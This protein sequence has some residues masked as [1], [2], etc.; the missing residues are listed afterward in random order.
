MPPKVVA[1]CLWGG[2]G[3]RQRSITRRDATQTSK[4][5]SDAYRN[6]N[7]VPKPLIPIATVPMS[8]IGVEKLNAAGIN[9]IYATT[10]V[11]HDA[12]QAYYL[13]GAG[14][15][16][17][18]KELWYENRPMG[19]APGLV[20]NL[21]LRASLREA[22]IVAPGGDIITDIN[23]N[24]FLN[25]HH[26]NQS[27]C[28]I[29]LNPVS[30]KVVHNFGTADF[31]PLEGQFGSI[32]AFKEK[33]PAKEAFGIQIEN[34]T[35]F[36]NN[37]SFYVFNPELFLKPMKGNKSILEMIFPNM[38][39]AL[40]SEIRSGKIDVRSDEEAKE[41]FNRFGLRDKKFSDFGGH[42]FPFLAQEGLMRGFVFE[43]YWN[44]VG[45]NETYWFANWH[46]LTKRFKMNL[47]YP[48]VEPGVWM[49][50]DAERIEGSVITPPVI[51]GKNVKIESGAKVGPYA[52]LDEG[53]TVERGAE[54][55]YSLTWPTFTTEGYQE[56]IPYQI[57]R[58]G[59]RIE[60]SIIAGRLPVGDH[61]FKNSIGDGSTVDQSRLIRTLVGLK[62]AMDSEID[63]AKQTKR[64]LVVDDEKPFRDIVV[65]NL[66]TAGWEFIETAGDL[67]EAQARL[68][69][70]RYDIIILDSV[71]SQEEKAESEGVTILK[72]QKINKEAL[73]CETPTLFWS[74]H[75]SMEALKGLSPKE[76]LTLAERNTILRVK[77]D[78]AQRDLS[79][80][81][82]KELLKI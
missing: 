57:I 1:I 46:A 7:A 26:E 71:L 48:E 53:W 16:L 24:D 39:A 80:F 27:L 4:I 45:D 42:I 20:I 30:D 51:I 33:A 28:T 64:V 69:S 55:V 65:G 77:D 70:T 40:L 8:R 72:E 67:E 66:K 14:K 23:I 11:L 82:I 44:D 19:T 75:K 73:N 41:H 25:A 12:I 63:V 43:E 22:T 32:A 47:P 74:A 13:E 79:D 54:V 60:K 61:V 31:K 50:P 68:R 29:A 15:K 9:E 81:I 76:G 18:V 36:L 3:S 56:G 52:I 49:A 21:M 38:D 59:A 10:H 17:G 62:I 6:M 34:R 37:S 78:I 2:F 35:V 5:K 58:A